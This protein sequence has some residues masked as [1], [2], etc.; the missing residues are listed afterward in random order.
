MIVH[1]VSLALA[2]G[3]LAAAQTPID[4]LFDKF[5]TA[6]SPADAAAIGEQIAAA[7]DFE[8]AYARLKQGRRYLD[9]E[10]SVRKDRRCHPWWS[11][12]LPVAGRVQEVEPR[13]K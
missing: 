12:K 6:E 2:V 5:F 4:G 13:P 9:V 3:V 11:G 1:L 8:G 10:R 7:A